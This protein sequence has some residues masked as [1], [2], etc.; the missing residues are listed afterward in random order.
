MMP[1]KQGKIL[2]PLPLALGKRK[3]EYAF[4]PGLG[5]GSAVPYEPCRTGVM[6]VQ[7]LAL[8][9]ESLKLYQVSIRG[10]ESHLVFPS[11]RLV[12]ECGNRKN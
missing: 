10:Q 3:P 4:Y 5:R 12:V 7:G 6:V 8:R 2:A 9:P 1:L 11:M